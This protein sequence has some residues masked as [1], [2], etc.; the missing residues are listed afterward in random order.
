MKRSFVAVLVVILAMAS[1]VGMTSRV[2]AATSSITADAA[3]LLDARTGTILY[4]RSPY[5]RRPPASTTKI[6]TAI[7]A[8]EKGYLSDVVTVSPSAAWTEGSSIYLRTGEKLTLEAL[9]WGALMESGNDACVAIAEHIAGSEKGFSQLQNAKARALGAWD[10]HF[11]NPHGLPD[12]DHYTSAYDLATIARYSLRNSKFQEIVRSQEQT[13][14]G[15]EGSRTFYNTNRLLWSYSGADGVK[16]GTTAEAGQCLVASATR[17]GR[18][19]VAVVLHSDDRWSDAIALLDYG[20]QETRLLNLFQAGEVIG[21]P[22]T[23]GFEASIPV[24]VERDLYLV[25]DKDAAERVERVLEV[26]TLRAPVERGARV[27]RVVVKLD[28]KTLAERDLVAAASAA[29][30]SPL[31]TFIWY[32]YRHLV[33][34]LKSW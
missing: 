13:L 9:L 27:G 7:V 26:P 24:R 3:V 31:T 34:V 6:L 12:P 28:G 2:Q 14:K 8:L 20:F 33:A 23:H 1:L 29:K 30:R 22:L 15:P 4:G 21:L 32:V 19:L 25:V 10:T 5:E 11:V 16:T 17:A 18:Q